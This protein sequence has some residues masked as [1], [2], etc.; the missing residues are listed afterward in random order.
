MNRN[1]VIKAMIS[2]GERRPSIWRGGVMQIWVTRACDKACFACTQGS[3]LSGK[4]GMISLEHF[5][6]ACQSLEGYFG[7]VGIFGGNPVLHPKFEDLCKIYEKYF[8]YEQRGIWC[9]H[10]KGKGGLLRKTFN[11]SVSNLNVHL[12]KEA[13]SEFSRDWPESVPI[14]KGLEGDSRHSSPFVAM[15]DVISDEEERWKLIAEC[16]INKYWS[17][18]LCV[19]RGELRGYF[20]EIAGSQAML[21]QEDEDYPDLGV[22]PSPGWWRLGMNDFA[23]QV[24]FYCHRCGIPMRAKGELAITGTTEYVS[25]VHKLIYKPKIKN[26]TV[27]N[28]INTR[29]IGLHKLKRSTEYI[30]NGNQNF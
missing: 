28:V 6:Q 30:K 19:V 2:P 8:P 21:H 29:Q 3:N 26:R 7:V 13:Y 10:P 27:L 22:E 15:L 4:P 24:D 17:A 18:M 1:Q 16:D 12:D 11:P 9:N 20:C 5:E 25:A 23:D 14:L